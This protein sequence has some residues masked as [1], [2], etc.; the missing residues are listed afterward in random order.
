MYEKTQNILK[1]AKESNT[2]VIGF[3]CQDYV[4]ARSV[5]YAAQAANTPALVMLYPE[6]VTVQHTTGLAQYAT[7]VKELANEVNVPVGLH[8]DHD[9]SYEAVMKTI[10]VGG[11]E[12]VM[13]DGSMN[14][15]DANIALTKSVVAEARKLGVCVEAEVGHIALAVEADLSNTDFFTKA[16]DAAKFCKETGVDSLAVSIGNAHGD[17]PHPPKLDIERL[18]EIRNATN[19]SL[20]LHGGSGIPDDQLKIAFSEGVNK[21]NLGTDY[22]RLYFEAVTKFTVDNK[23]NPNAVKIIDMPEYCQAILQPYV[24]ERLKT[25]CKF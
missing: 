20:V 1:M 14:D 12:S 16:D 17:Y 21:F 19:T 22:L 2:S 6:H 10:K 23:D 3:I 9:Y 25:L 15:L 5:V 13:I 4:M 7:M 18:K 24:E 11:F 8:M